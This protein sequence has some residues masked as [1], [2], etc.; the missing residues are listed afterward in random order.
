MNPNDDFLRELAEDSAS[1]YR[2]R[3]NQEL[4]ALLPAI[5]DLVRSG[6]SIRSITT[7]LSSSPRS[8]LHGVKRETIERA[9]FRL[10]K[11]GVVQDKVS[12]AAALAASFPAVASPPPAPVAPPVTASPAPGP[13]ASFAFP[14]PASAPVPAPAVAAAAPVVAS[15]S[16]APAPA[17][18]A[19]PRSAYAPSPDAL[20]EKRAAEERRRAERAAREKL[21]EGIQT[22]LVP[23]PWPVHPVL[24][25][26]L[27]P[28]FCDPIDGE[29][30]PFEVV[31]PAVQV[32]NEVNWKSS[33]KA[34]QFPPEVRALLMQHLQER[35]I[36]QGGQGFFTRWTP[37]QTREIARNIQRGLAAQIEIFRQAAR[38]GKS[39]DPALISQ[40]QNHAED[41]LVDRLLMARENWRRLLACIQ[42]EMNV[43][44]IPDRLLSK[45]QDN[46][47][48]TGRFSGVSN[49]FNFGMWEV[50][51]GK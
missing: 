5:Q 3:I 4:M 13:A 49:V 39:V 18:V 47:H 21:S 30:L 31:P 35:G 10:L 2:S 26:P 8:P 15:A 38:D 41:A 50:V 32:V 42:I 20:A 1:R 44:Q 17:P 22:F 37:Q 16:V 11:R 6:K 29:D 27:E 46:P 19:A 43:F 14:A 51:A 25:G 36:G 40:Y 9:Y 24:Q 12:P 45:L 28:R 23:E 34:F 7:I 48:L 33:G